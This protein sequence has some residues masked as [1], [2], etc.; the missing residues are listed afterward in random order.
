MKI[1]FRLADRPD[2]SGIIWFIHELARLEGMEEQITAT[3]QE[4]ESSIFE[5]QQ[6]EILIAEKDG[7]YAGF[8]LF[9]PVYS[10]FTGGNNLFLEDFLVCEEYRGQGIGT[11]MIQKLQQIARQRGAKRLDWYVLNNNE[12]GARFYR[13]LGAKPL[14]DRKVYRLEWK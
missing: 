7:N 8:A 9:Y 3:E 1:R 6:A 2:L 5:K 14:G 10:T 13:K 4:I 11:Q 12:R